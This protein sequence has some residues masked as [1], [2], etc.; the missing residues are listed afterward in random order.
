MQEGIPTPIPAF[1]SSS[2]PDENSSGRGIFDAGTFSDSSFRRK[3][4][5]SLCVDDWTPDLAPDADPGF[6]GVTER[7]VAGSS[8]HG[9]P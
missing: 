3:P 9:G 4:E 8:A 5:S 2:V 7:R 1:R 6:A